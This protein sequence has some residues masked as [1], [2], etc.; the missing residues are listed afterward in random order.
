MNRMTIFQISMTR[1]TAML[2]L[3]ATVSFVAAY[4]HAFQ[5]L[6]AK[7][8]DSDEYSH[9][10]LTIPIIVYMVWRSREAFLVSQPKYPWVGL[11]MMIAATLLYPLSLII[12]MRTIIGLSMC[13]MLAGAVVFFSGVSAL[14]IMATPLLLMLILIPVPDQLYTKVTFPLQLMVSQISEWF[15][16]LLGVPIFREGNVMNIPG[17][18][19]EVVEACS[20][21]RSIIT[22]LTLSVIIGYFMLDNLASK[23][24]LVCTSIPTAIFVNILRLV[25]MIALFYHAGIDLSV[26]KLHTATGIAIFIV[27]LLILFALQRLLERWKIKYK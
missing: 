17:R 16:S 27:A 21:L 20:G 13:M 3:A 26:G 8:L 22:L 2:S 19:F 7:W 24:M 25:T 23:L 10:F 9:A 5:I 15:V 6:G 11:V 1:K 14:K 18:S 12:Q 4:W